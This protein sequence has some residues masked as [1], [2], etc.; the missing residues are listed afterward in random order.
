MHEIL[1]D[2]MIEPGELTASDWREEIPTA[3]AEK[4]TGTH[5]GMSQFLLLHRLSTRLQLLHHLQKQSP[6]KVRDSGGRG[7]DKGNQFFELRGL[8]PGADRPKT[9]RQQCD[10]FCSNDNLAK[11]QWVGV[12]KSHART[13]SD[14]K[15]HNKVE[16]E[17]GAFTGIHEIGNDAC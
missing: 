2:H 17:A 7:C 10:L 6:T 12:P 15:V 9:F 11:N 3:G 14:S 8:E 13:H 1:E 4:S 5:Q 16:E